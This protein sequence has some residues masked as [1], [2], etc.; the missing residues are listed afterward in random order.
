M[1]TV[2]SNYVFGSVSKEGSVS[3]FCGT[4]A[5]T[6]LIALF[7]SGKVS[8]RLKTVLGSFA[9][10]FVMIL[11]WEPFCTVFSLFK[12]VSSFWYRYSYLTIFGIL[13]IAAFFYLAFLDKESPKQCYFCR[14][15]APAAS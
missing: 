14:A 15:S 7:L 3:M 1:S 9:V 5:I 10:L 8:A 11:Y 2:L 12:A 6:G 4:F 13:F